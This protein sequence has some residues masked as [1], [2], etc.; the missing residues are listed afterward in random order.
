M[1]HSRNR[2]VATVDFTHYKNRN[3]LKCTEMA[4][5][6]SKSS[7]NGS[8]KGHLNFEVHALHAMYTSRHISMKVFIHPDYIP[9]R[10]NVRISYPV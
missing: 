9:M 4:L 8:A 6:I 1:F 7:K 3:V 5:G 10:T 2:K